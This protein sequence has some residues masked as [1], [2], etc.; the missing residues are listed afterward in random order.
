MTDA[1]R[2]YLKNLIEGLS[3]ENLYTE[4]PKLIILYRTVDFP[5]EFK[6]LLKNKLC[7]IIAQLSKQKNTVKVSS[8]DILFIIRA[9]EYFE[10]RSVIFEDIDQIRSYILSKNYLLNPSNFIQNEIIYFSKIIYKK[11]EEL[12]SVF[13]NGVPSAVALTGALRN[14]SIE[15]FRGNCAALKECEI[16]KLYDK[17]ML[18]EFPFKISYH[19]RDFRKKVIEKLDVDLSSLKVEVALRD[20]KV[21]ESSI[22]NLCILLDHGIHDKDKIFDPIVKRS[23]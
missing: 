23:R 19:D 4:L 15:F 17:T 5:D 7:N 22:D 20:K 2:V 18:S 16:E 6:I 21:V 9:I 1:E 12:N 8:A 13:L 11:L 10:D 3:F 14:E